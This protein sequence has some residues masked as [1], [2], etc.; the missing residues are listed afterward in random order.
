M[1]MEEYVNAVLRPLLRGD[2]GEIEYLGR[3][4]NTVFVRL[5][6]EC[7]FCAKAELCLRWCEVK[8]EKDRGERVRFSAEKRR[9]YFRDQ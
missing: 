4:G 5:R 8:A 9:P 2:G 3:E 6:G 1:N 7:S